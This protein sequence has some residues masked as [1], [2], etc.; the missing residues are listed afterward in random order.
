MRRILLAVVGVLIVGCSSGC[1]S[2]PAD[3]PPE[4]SGEMVD[5][6]SWYV[7]NA[8]PHDG[9]PVEST[10]FVVYSD[11][12]GVRARHEVAS[13]AENAWSELMDELSIEPGMLRFPD[14]RDK[15]DV[16]AYHDHDPRDWSGRAYY[17]GLLVWSPDHDQRRAGGGERLAPV[18]KHEL[19]HVIQ[20]LID[21]GEDLPVDTWFFEGLALALAGDIASVEGRDQL[22]RLTAR[23]GEAS[24]VSITSY[25]QIA[26]PE[27]GERF[28]YPMFRVAVEYLMDEDGHG[29]SPAD[30]TLML[31][32][33]ADG[34]SFESAFEDR[35]GLPLDDYDNDFFQL[36]AAYLPRYRNP[37]FAPVPFAVLSLLVTLLVA[38]AVV[39]GHR[40]WRLAGS[41]GSTDVA[42]SG[43]VARA[44][45]SV[46]L[47]LA[48]VI[49]I[50][51]FLGGLLVVGT[52][53]VL[54]RAGYGR[55]R[56][57]AYTILGSYLLG[58]S[59]ILLW[60]V[61][62]WSRRSRSAFLVAPF[63]I[64]ATGGGIASLII[65]STII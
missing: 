15:I 51:F 26:T 25:S 39:V 34:A 65:A 31:V 19:V 46:E 27:A 54:Y 43:R 38:G 30:M 17:G 37:V 58:S 29:K 55:L 5:E 3:G 59:I 20:S 12:A 57:V 44:G 28:Y 18:I 6:G 9:N 48:F 14:G 50:V 32:D 1:A 41:P 53:D 40:R 49:V 47:T 36:M 35:M 8:W 52:E 23:Y 22:D 13:I 16:Y 60:A 33:V 61:R 7:R 10:N 11:A 4:G 45:F 63:I 21:G 64:L 42:G 62:Q 2:S 56:L 24:P